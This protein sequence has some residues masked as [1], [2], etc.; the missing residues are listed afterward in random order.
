MTD[1]LP[2]YADYYKCQFVV[3]SDQ[4]HKFGIQFQTHKPIVDS[5][6]IVLLY[7]EANMEAFTAMD[8][9]ISSE[10]LDHIYYIKNQFSFQTKLA[11]QCYD[12]YNMYQARSC[13]L[14]TSPSPRDA[15]LS[16]MPS[17]A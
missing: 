10:K 11:F 16:R 13:L 3:Y 7:Q 17:S 5:L 12:C 4:R 15:T 2:K 6:P 8:T 14:Y 9:D 1:I